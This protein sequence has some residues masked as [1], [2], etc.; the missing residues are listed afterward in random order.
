MKIFTKYN[1]DFIRQTIGDDQQN[2]NDDLQNKV[3]EDI[4]L[5]KEE[6][7]RRALI[8]LGWTP[9]KDDTGEYDCC[10][11]CGSFVIINDSHGRLCGKDD[12]LCSVCYWRKRGEVKD[13]GAPLL[14]DTLSALY[15]LYHRWKSE[16]I[17]F[18]NDELLFLIDTLA[19][20][21]DE[22]SKHTDS[23]SHR[24]CERLKAKI[25]ICAWK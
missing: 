9:P 21:C 17:E 20:R 4:I 16:N 23:E 22:L 12:D 10:V 5:L 8:D 6:G 18:T 24:I 13:G 1:K 15:E 25:D 2:Y 7:V 19:K 14:V 11:R 3:Y